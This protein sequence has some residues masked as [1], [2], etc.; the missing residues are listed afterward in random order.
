MPLTFHFLSSNETCIVRLY[1]CHTTIQIF[2]SMSRIVTFIPTLAQ[3]IAIPPPINPAPTIPTDLFF[4]FCTFGKS[5]TF[6]PAL[7]TKHVQ[8]R[9]AFW[10]RT[11]WRKQSFSCLTILPW[12][13]VRSFDAFN[14]GFPSRLSLCLE[15][16]RFRNYQNR[17]ALEVAF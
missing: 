6:F 16:M 13:F 4:C 15:A 1:Q 8:H 3:H 17:K 7:S 10:R 14:D 2:L 11:Q 9:S 5:L 12:P